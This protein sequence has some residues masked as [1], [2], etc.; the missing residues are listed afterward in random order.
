MSESRTSKP[1]TRRAAR[2]TESI[3]AESIPEQNQRAQ[4]RQQDREQRRAQS[5]TLPNT[6]TLSAM[7]RRLQRHVQANGWPEPTLS[8]VQHLMARACGARHWPELAAREV[9]ALRASTEPPGP[10]SKT[11]PDIRAAI[12]RG[13][14]PTSLSVLALNSEVNLRISREIMPRDIAQLVRWSATQG[15]AVYIGGELPPGIENFTRLGRGGNLERNA[16]LPTHTDPLSAI[17]RAEALGHFRDPMGLQ[18]MMA[19]EELDLIA[20]ARAGHAPPDETLDQRR[21]RYAQALGDPERV[22]RDI[23]ETAYGQSAGVSSMLMLS[24]LKL[25]EIVS[26]MIPA[27]LKLIEHLNDTGFDPLEP[28][29]PTDLQ[30]AMVIWEQQSREFGSIIHSEWIRRCSAP[31]LSLTSWEEGQG[32]ASA[33][34]YGASGVRRR[35]WWKVRWN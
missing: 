25:S 10:H 32:F 29:R 22:R 23:G 18:I 5:E 21:W 26:A 15:A 16:A 28:R 13:E 2:Q 34:T 35:T 14:L 33:D 19:L 31:V 30:G 12:Q 24:H 8:N 17:R 27:R 11:P 9:Q 1:R 3:Q 20:A 4:N 6:R 7:S